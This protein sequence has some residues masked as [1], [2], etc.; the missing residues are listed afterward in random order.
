MSAPAVLAQTEALTP[1]DYSFA[2]AYALTGH[3]LPENFA[4]VTT[5]AAGQSGDDVRDAL[6]A[7][8]ADAMGVDPADVTPLAL[9][10]RRTAVTR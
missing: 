9:R 1:G 6:T 10:L 5:V 7:R 2:A 4:G 8:F 3:A